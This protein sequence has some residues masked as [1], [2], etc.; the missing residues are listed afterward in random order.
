LNRSLGLALAAAATL[1][2]CAATAGD[3]V[4][5]R[6]V[7]IAG[8]DD[9]AHDAGTT[10]PSSP[11]TD[12]GSRVG[13]DQFYD[14]LEGSETG[15]DS[16]TA[17]VL[18]K[19]VDG[20]FPGLK[21]AASIVLELNHTRLL[22]GD[23]RALQD[24]GSYIRAT[25][26]FE[27]GTLDVLLM[28]FRSDRLRLGYL[29]DITWGGDGVFPG[30]APVPGLKVSWDAPLYG[31]HVGMKTSR[32]PYNTDEEDARKGQLEAFFGFFGGA[33]LGR[34][35]DGFRGDVG[36]GSFQKGTNPNGS[37]RGEP[38]TSWGVSARVAYI[39]GLPFVPNNDL[40]IYTADPTVPF[41]EWD[42][43]AET[44]AFR[45][46]LEATRVSQLL[47]DPDSVGGT[48][49]EPGLAGAA[50]GQAQ[51]GFWRLG[52]TGIFRDL[53]FM[54]FNGPGTVH[55]YQAAPED[56]DQNPELTGVVSVQY[57]IADWHLTPGLELG[58]QQPAGA[59]N[60]VP[61]AGIHA[62]SVLTGRR[63]VVYRRA[64]MFDDTGLTYPSI[65]P[66]GEDIVP[67]FGARLSTQLALARGFG[68]TAAFTVLQ[69]ANRAELVQDELQ[70]NSLRKFT[71]ALTF[72][73]SVMARA[74][75]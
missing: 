38:V 26:T 61:Q 52:A 19:A 58:A 32:L 5:T 70:V 57:R 23:P 28:P 22:A 39:D 27:T 2:P 3:F 41:T 1:A 53:A 33:R 51:L 68:V 16:R 64:D 14:Q 45:V 50:Y 31:T 54:H 40:R 60:L 13:Y 66:D 11:T 15:R 46:A 18:H 6:L 49:D 44:R 9:F 42:A 35:A 12:I 55:R 63:T 65:L 30:T 75:F 29:W 56:L 21:T 4:D 37:V 10:I 69:D 67:T 24:D 71:S 59:S 36:L 62:P 47:E 17:L 20:Y 25:Q 74:E 48:K 73:A 8:D 72:G 7:F 34:E 43:T